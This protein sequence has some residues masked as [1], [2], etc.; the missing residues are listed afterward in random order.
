MFIDS[1]ESYIDIDHTDQQTY[2][3]FMTDNLETHEII[4]QI[5]KLFLEDHEQTDLKEKLNLLKD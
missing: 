5:G 1:F 3:F 2:H 4:N